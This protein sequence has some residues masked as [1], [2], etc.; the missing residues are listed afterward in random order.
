MDSGKASASAHC[1][2]LVNTIN[3]AK[4]RRTIE[5]DLFHMD[6]QHVPF[7][8]ILVYHPIRSEHSDDHGNHL[9]Q[10]SGKDKQSRTLFQDCVTF[11]IAE[12][13]SQLGSAWRSYSMLFEI[14]VAT[15]V[16]YRHSTNANIESIPADSPRH[17]T[18]VSKPTIAATTLRRSA[19]ETPTRA[20]PHIP[21]C[22]PPRLAHP[23]D[24]WP[25]QNGRL[26]RRLVR[27]CSL[28]VQKPCLCRQH[29]PATDGQDVL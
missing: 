24:L 7:T 17:T 1:K 4:G 10:I 29:A 3:I 6:Q 27:R 19:E 12:K 5:L 26:P 2:M 14:N 22:N 8:R 16:P 13:G 11:Q 21:V 23:V 15:S 9:C 20:R 25:A 28:P 18:P